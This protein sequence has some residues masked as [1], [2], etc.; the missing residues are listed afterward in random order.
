MPILPL[1]IE[2]LILLKICLYLNPQVESPL[3]AATVVA[4]A[5]LSTAIPGRPSL[6][7][8]GFKVK[9]KVI[10]QSQ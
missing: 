2:L 7:P 4:A 1:V 6:P 9:V 5:V 8:I 10:Q 3:F